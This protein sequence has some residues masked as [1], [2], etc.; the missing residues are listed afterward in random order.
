MIDIQAFVISAF[1]SMFTTPEYIQYLIDDRDS[2]ILLIKVG[3]THRFHC[4]GLQFA[5][6]ADMPGWPRLAQCGGRAS[7]VLVR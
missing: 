6:F 1:R 5:V 7:H 4:S 3:F 2:C